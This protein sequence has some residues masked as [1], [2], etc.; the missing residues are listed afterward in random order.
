EFAEEHVRRGLEHRAPYLNLGFFV[1]RAVIYFAIWIAIAAVLRRWSFT[2][3]REDRPDLSHRMYV[4]GGVGLPVVALAIIFS[5]F[6]WLMAL[7]PAWRS[8]MFPIYVFASG[9]VGAIALLT[10]LTFAAHRAGHLPGLE[11]SHYYALGRL[12]LAFTIFWA[13][14]A[15]FQFM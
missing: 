10:A 5:S 7:D 1:V 15:F 8:T 2:Q 11:S 13:Y 12:L 14:A 6:D 4:L 3:D 9:F